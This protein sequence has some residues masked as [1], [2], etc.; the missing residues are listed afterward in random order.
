MA[1]PSLVLAQEDQPQEDPPDLAFFTDYPVRVA[2]P[3]DSVTFDLNLSG[4]AEPETLHLDVE[5]LPE[6]W[7]A[8]FRGGGDVVEAA[9]VEPEGGRA[10]DLKVE[11]P[12]DVSVDTYNFLVI[13]H[14]DDKRL[15]IPLGVTVREKVPP[16]L[17]FEV[18][19]PTLKGRADTTFRYDATLTNEGNQ[20]L[21]I[22][23]IAEAPEGF[24]VSFKLSGQEVS[25]FP[26]GPGESKRLDVEVQPPDDALADTYEIGILAQGG[27]AQA[28]TTLVADVTRAPGEPSLDVTGP[29]GRLS[30]EA[31]I[32]EKTPIDIVIRNSG[33]AAARNVT[34]SASEPSAYISHP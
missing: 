24:Q 27:A 9:H 25:S 1:L 19:L 29:G 10:V 4:G 6:G 17:S 28:R 11:L 34:L 13:A 3:G 18:E 14:S 22:N 31:T 30:A 7:E 12:K 8:T 26:I 21:S 33:D 32:G 16:S 15:E 23:L 20:D 5:G 2:T